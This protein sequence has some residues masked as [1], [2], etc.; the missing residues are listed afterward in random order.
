MAS[1]QRD[2][3]SAS[4]GEGNKLIAWL[5]LLV[6]I[7]AVPVGL[8]VKSSRPVEPKATPDKKWSSFLRN[9]N[10]LLVLRLS[11]M[12]YDDSDESVSFFPNVTRQAM[13]DVS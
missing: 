8:S 5:I 13:S 4:S 10:R 1:S 11:G 6:C 12:I 9:E 7:I 2:A 3:L